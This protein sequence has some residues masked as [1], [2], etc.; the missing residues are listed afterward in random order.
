MQKSPD[1]LS[2]SDLFVA[3]LE[4]HKMLWLQNYRYGAN[5]KSVNSFLCVE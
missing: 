2:L 1:F 5:F 3:L 4:L